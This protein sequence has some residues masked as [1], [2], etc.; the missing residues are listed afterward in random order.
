MCGG[1]G[2]GASCCGGRRAGLSSSGQCNGDKSEQVFQR[3][4]ERVDELLGNGDW[5]KWR[6]C[7]CYADTSMVRLCKG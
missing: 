7:N 6:R 2:A 1:D 3:H 4:V 5:S